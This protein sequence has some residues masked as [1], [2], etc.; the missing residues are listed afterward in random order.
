M[1]RIL[2][3]YFLLTAIPLI[4]S[5]FNVKSGN[6]FQVKKKDNFPIQL[7]Y[8]D[9]DK[10]IY[11]KG[12]IHYLVK[13]VE[14]LDRN[15]RSVRKLALKTDSHHRVDHVLW[16]GE[17]LILLWEE[18]VKNDRKL[19]FQLIA[20]NG[21]KTNKSLLATLEEGFSTQLRKHDVITLESP[22][23]DFFGFVVKEVT[24]KNQ[25]GKDAVFVK[26]TAVFDKKGKLLHQ[27]KEVFSEFKYFDGFNFL[28]DSGQIVQIQSNS[29]D[30]EILVQKNS[31]TNKIR[32]TYRFETDL[33]QEAKILTY[34]TI[35]NPVTCT[36]DFIS[37]IK[38]H[39]SIQGQNGTYTLKIDLENNRIL[40][41]SQVVFEQDFIDYFRSSPKYSE[42]NIL[43]DS[44]SISND[45][46][47]RKVLTQSDGSLYVISENYNYFRPKFLKEQL[48]QEYSDGVF[49]RFDA[50]YGLNNSY[51]AMD[52]I[53]THIDSYGNID[54]VRRVPKSQMGLG[55]QYGSFDAYVDSNELYIFYNREKDLKSFTTTID[56]NHVVVKNLVPICK[57]INPEGEL[58]FFNLS[59]ILDKKMIFFPLFSFSYQT[60]PKS[61][62]TNLTQEKTYKTPSNAIFIQMKVKSQSE[63]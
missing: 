5:D 12:N 62:F 4:A 46:I 15:L 3:L 60:S 8:A 1:S 23:K 30:R 29:E 26:F 22:G 21:R 43:A 13:E 27:E 37:T 38:N 31:F 10:I 59:K 18:K 57:K 40:S 24:S 6:K 16:T 11:T 33:T 19:S 50:N 47:F 32:E 42:G 61:Y 49:S 39:D 36:Y 34:H 45:F 20:Q 58:T 17:H 54:W 35:F 51:N 25:N 41:S 14:F 53:V 63:K 28:T 48:G 56:K 55:F 44:L 9:Y 52:M 7:I 2:T